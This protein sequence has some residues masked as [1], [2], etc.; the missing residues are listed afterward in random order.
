MKKKIL[1]LLFAA[2]L[3]SSCAGETTTAET[4]P[5]DTAAEA[6]TE[7]ETTDLMVELYG[8]I[9]YEGQEFR[10]Y[11]FD[12]DG[13]FYAQCFSNFHELWSGESTGE[14]LNDAIY[15]RNCETEEFL[16]IAITPVYGGE[17]SAVQSGLTRAVTAGSND[18]DAVFNRMDFFDAPLLAGALYNLKSI[19]PIDTTHP[20]W[21]KMIVDSFTLFDSRLYWISGDFNI[22][23]DYAAEAVFFN[24]KLCDDYDLAYPYDAVREGKWTVDMFY[25]MGQ[26]VVTDVNGD[27]KLTVADD[28]VGHIEQNDH[29]KHW[30]YA[31]GEKSVNLNTDKSL[32]VRTL[33]ER[34]VDV[35]NKLFDLMVDKAMTY[36]G[37]TVDFI[38]GHGLF[39]GDMIAFIN[40]M[41]DM[42]TDFGVVPMPKYDESQEQ[43]GAYVSNGWTTAMAVPVT[44]TDTDFIGTCMEVL[45]ATSTDTVRAAIYDVMLTNKLIRDTESVEMM[46]IIF[47][48]KSYD[49]AVD[50]SW[51]SS[52]KSA[53][54]TLYDSKN[55]NYVS[56]STSKL[57][58]QQKTLQNLI[59]TISGFPE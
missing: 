53:Y 4:T 37:L 45:S 25:D 27:G 41:R 28:V 55:N 19:D 46:D 43:Y 7:T 18:F 47:A 31:L 8:G 49:W 17:T 26:T 59:D 36:T 52:F 29:V 2:L 10:I 33:T 12:I 58:A 34:H 32:E 54:Q 38:E 16:N 24:K 15:N 56:A 3:L 30:I 57:E 9:D 5:T 21:D 6:V 51:G 22:L 48:G 1:S 11:T 14:I 20:W 42:E 35:V 50:F 23:D 40:K 13:H 44:C 39:Y